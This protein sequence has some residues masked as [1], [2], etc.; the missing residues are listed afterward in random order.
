MTFRH[1]VASGD[2]LPDTVV[3]WTRWTPP[4]GAVPPETDVEWVV[5]LDP[6]LRQVVAGGGQECSELQHCMSPFRDDGA[7]V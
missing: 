4:G 3:L 7:S 5:A 2:P 6:D 1:G